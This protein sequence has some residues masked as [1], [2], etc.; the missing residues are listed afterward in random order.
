M[1]PVS[2]TKR[3]QDLKSGW[4]LIRF[5]SIEGGEEVSLKTMLR[6]ALEEEFGGGD[7]GA[8]GHFSVS[9]AA[10]EQPGKPALAIDDSRARV[11]RLGE[12]TRLVV[13]R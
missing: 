8:V 3:L 1:Q 5:Q 13:A 9:S 10:S 7:V 6:H 12:G 4:H 11:A 2:C